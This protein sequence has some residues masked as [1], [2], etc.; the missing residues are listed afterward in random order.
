MKICS[1][2]NKCNVTVRNKAPPILG[3]SVTIPGKPKNCYQKHKETIW[4]WEWHKRRVLGLTK[5]RV[6]ELPKAHA[7][8]II[9]SFL[10]AVYCFDL[11]Q[12]LPIRDGLRPGD[13]AIWSARPDPTEVVI[14][15]ETGLAGMVLT[16]RTKAGSLYTI[17]HA[18]F[19]RTAPTSTWKQSQTDQRS[20]CTS[21]SRTQI[22]DLKAAPG[23]RL[24]VTQTKVKLKPSPEQWQEGEGRVN[25]LKDARQVSLQPA[26]KWHWHSEQR[27]PWISRRD[28]KSNLC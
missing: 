11:F 14:A 23:K 27:P 18:N 12:L 19:P 26:E 6:K 24:K 1:S 5:G 2:N 9:A 4:A 25:L 21:S 8:V 16:F 13:S 3:A 10:A 28:A 20:V 17:R 22:I 15:A 7:A